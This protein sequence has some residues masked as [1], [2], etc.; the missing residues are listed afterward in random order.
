M[1]RERVT[2]R[3]QGALVVGWISNTDAL[4][5]GLI[6][7]LT[8]TM[9]VAACLHRSEGKNH[10]MQGNLVSLQ[11]QLGQAQGRVVDLQA[12]R[13]RIVGLGRQRIKDLNTSLASLQTTY[14][15]LMAA[16]EK[17]TEEGRHLEADNEKL[18]AN[19]VAW[20]DAYLNMKKTLEQ[21]TNEKGDA[22]IRL[23]SATEERDLARQEVM[24]LRNR[25]D[26]EPGLHKELIGLKGNLRRVAVIFDTSGSMAESGRWEQARGVVGTWL[27]HLAISECVLILF[28][29][30]AQIF[31]EDGAFLDMHGP[32]GV[33]NRR[34]LLNRIEATKPDGG[35]NTLLALQTAYRC[36]NLDT[37]ILFTDGEP[38]NPKGIVANQ[39][40]PQ[41]AEKIYT[42]LQQHKDIPVNT[43]GLGNYFKPQLS[44]FLMRVAR[45]TGGS[46]LGR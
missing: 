9:G 4:F 28:S 37:I 45:D 26:A 30:D 29:N 17:A 15:Q 31:P 21:T 39:F 10:Q 2:R 23:V 5:L 16:T 27:E 32:R 20:R 46:F 8:V 44:G 14:T 1:Q 12:E 6:F 7:T 19:L 18:K 40:D 25:I 38:N 43:V 22:A 11:G 42:L 41:V 34:L 35:T 3:S 36:P 33:A 24:A 13:E